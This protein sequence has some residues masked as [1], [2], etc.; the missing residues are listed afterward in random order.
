MK[1][2]VLQDENWFVIPVSLKWPSG[3]T[4]I[5]EDEQ[6]ME[7]DHAGYTP[8]EVEDSDGVVEHLFLCDHCPAWSYDAEDWNV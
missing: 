3:T 4:Q 5:I 1:T 2:A 7:C 6:V 8:G